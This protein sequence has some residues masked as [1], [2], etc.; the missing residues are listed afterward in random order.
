MFDQAVENPVVT[1]TQD[2]QYYMAVYF[3]FSGGIGFIWS[4]DGL[5][6][7]QGVHL[8]VT[9]ELPKPCGG[10]P[11]TALGLVAATQLQFRL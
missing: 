7:S 10:N 2:K 4:R 11:V 1:M 8:N 6:W 9:K 5:Q 3:P